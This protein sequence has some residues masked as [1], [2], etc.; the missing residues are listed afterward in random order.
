MAPVTW[1]EKCVSPGSVLFAVSRSY[2]INEVCLKGST[3]V[4]MFRH[5]VLQPAPR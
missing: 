4:E 2:S 1:L 5:T 3:T